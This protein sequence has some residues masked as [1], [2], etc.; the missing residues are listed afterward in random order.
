M[1][2]SRPQDKFLAYVVWSCVILTS[3]GGP[4]SD[5]LTIPIQ[6]GK[7]DATK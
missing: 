4:L 3:V 5:E 2:F 6:D 1:F 7:L